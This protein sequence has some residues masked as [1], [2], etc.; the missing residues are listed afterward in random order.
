MMN[1]NQDTVDPK[2]PETNTNDEEKITND[3]SNDTSISPNQDV[4][5]QKLSNTATSPHLLDGKK[6]ADDTSNVTFKVGYW[7]L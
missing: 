2:L 3:T 7:D 6:F 4:V 5:A 1:P